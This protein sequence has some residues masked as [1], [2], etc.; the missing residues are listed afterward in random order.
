M[1][2]DSRLPSALPS[3]SPSTSAVNGT[4]CTT[5]RSDFARQTSCWASTKPWISAPSSTGLRTTCCAAKALAFQRS[6]SSM[7][8]CSSAPWS[9]RMRTIS[10]W[11]SVSG[12]AV[13]SSSSETPSFSAASGVFRSCETWRRKRALSASVSAR[14]WRSQSSRRAMRCTSDGPRMCTG[15]SRPS[16]PRPRMACST[17]CSG[18]ASHQAKPSASVSARATVPS[19]CWPSASRPASSSCCSAALRASVWRRAASLMRC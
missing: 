19:S 6:R 3:R 8:C 15:V 7:R 12:P 4:P 16:S 9:C 14:R 17:R 13:P 5:M 10:R 2:L 11:L 1:A 18:R